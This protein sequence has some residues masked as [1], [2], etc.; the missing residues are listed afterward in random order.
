MTTDPKAD[1]PMQTAVSRRRVLTSLGLLALLGIA[2]PSLV[3][4]DEAEAGGKRK[5][6]RRK[7]VSRGRGPKK[8]N[9]GRRVS[10]VAR[11]KSSTGKRVS[12]VAR[13]KKS[14]S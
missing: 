6:G 12:R 11:R 13:R 7:S 10:K 4:P 8:H 1:G 5:K 3:A 9:H 14:F 2:G